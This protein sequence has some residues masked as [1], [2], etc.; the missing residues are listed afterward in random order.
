MNIFVTVFLIFINV[1]IALLVYNTYNTYHTYNN[2]SFTINTI[3]KSTNETTILINTSSLINNISSNINVIR[4]HPKISTI[5]NIW[6][7]LVL[8]MHIPKCAGASL[9]KELSYKCKEFKFFS[10]EV[11][12]D[13]LKREEKEMIEKGYNFT[14]IIHLT[15]VRDPIAHVYSQFLECKHDG[16]GKTVTNKTTFPRNYSDEVG[17]E[18]WL[19]HF[20][21]TWELKK[22]YY[23]CYIPFNAQTRA[24]TCGGGNN[25]LLNYH[26]KAI[27]FTITDPLY[28]DLSIAMDNTLLFDHIGVVEYYDASICLFM[29]KIHGNL[30]DSCFNLCKKPKNDNDNKDEK[31]KIF[32]E[33]HNVPYHSADKLSQNI[34]K[35]IEKITSHDK[36]LYDN[37]L[38]RFL[39]DI[40]YLEELYHSKLIC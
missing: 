20:D 1:I 2:K 14:K 26:S 11:C 34:T 29:F 32:H 38:K 13:Y 9:Q 4:P 23:N 6:K 10:N 22:G 30:S 35:K 16:W 19:D 7:G 24:F 25:H 17:L 8:L 15:M 36:I 18:K 33:R 37:L 27:S 31:N 21:E 5:K 39:D 3:T 40:K 12:Y 28:P